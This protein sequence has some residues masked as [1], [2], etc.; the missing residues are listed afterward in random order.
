MTTLV[1]DTAADNPRPDFSKTRQPCR[2]RAGLPLGSTTCMPITVRATSCRASRSMCTKA[3][4]LRLLGRNGAG[5]TSTLRTLARL[6][7]SP[8]DPW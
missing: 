7:Q 5:K 3:K 4:S 2:H 6:G 8:G 1:K